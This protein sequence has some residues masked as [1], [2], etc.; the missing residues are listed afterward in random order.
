[1]VLLFVS[2]ILSVPLSAMN[3]HCL[4]LGYDNQGLF[5]MC[6]SSKSS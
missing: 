3:T 6:V 1:M 2:E 4:T 5:C